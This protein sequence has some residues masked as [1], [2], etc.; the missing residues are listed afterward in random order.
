[1]KKK[2]YN[3]FIISGK[4]GT[5][6]THILGKIF[7]QSNNQKTALNFDFFKKESPLS[8]IENILNGLQ[9]NYNEVFEIYLDN[10]EDILKNLDETKEFFNRLSLNINIKVILTCNTKYLKMLTLVLKNKTIINYKIKEI[11]N[12]DFFEIYN[13][14]MNILRKNNPNLNN[15]F[16]LDLANSINTTF[17]GDFNR[18]NNFIGN[19]IK[20]KNKI[21]EDCLM[22]KDIIK[23]NIENTPLLND[24]VVLSILT[25]LNILRIPTPIFVLDYLLR[26]VGW[27]TN[28]IIDINNYLNQ[29]SDLIDSFIKQD[30]ESFVIIKNRVLGEKQFLQTLGIKLIDNNREI[31]YSEFRNWKLIDQSNVRLF[32]LWNLPSILILNKE[33]LLLEKIILDINY[34]TISF[35]EFES[36]VVLHFL[37]IIRVLTQNEN[38]QLR[39]IERLIDNNFTLLS[40][41]MLKKERVLTLLQIFSDEK[42]DK[43]FS[44]HS[45]TN[46]EKNLR[47]NI[48]E[49]KVKSN[50]HDGEVYALIKNKDKIYF[51]IKSFSNNN[52]ILYSMRIN[53]VFGETILEVEGYINDIIIQDNIIYLISSYSKLLSIKEDNGIFVV[54]VLIENQNSIFRKIFIH[55]S[56]IYIGGSMNHILK[57]STQSKT[58]EQ[59]G[60][61]KGWVYA[62]SLDLNS[63]LLVIVTNSGNIY[64]YDLDKERVSNEIQTGYSLTSSWVGEKI[65][66]SDRYGIIHMFNSNTLFEEENI[67][68][69]D[70]GIY[71]F[72]VF[73][74]RIVST[75]YSGD[76]SL[77]DC[78]TESRKIIFT[79]NQWATALE[80]SSIVNGIIFHAGMDGRVIE[81]NLETG[82]SKIIYQPSKFLSFYIS[83]MEVGIYI[84]DYLSSSISA[85]TLDGCLQL[86]I[87]LIS[88]GLIFFSRFYRKFDKIEIKNHYIK[89]KMGRFIFIGIIQKN[90]VSRFIKSKRRIKIG[91]PS[92]YFEIKYNY[93]RLIKIRKKGIINVLDE[94][95][96]EVGFFNFGSLILD[97][98][99]KDDNI[100]LLFEREG[101]KK[102]SFNSLL[103]S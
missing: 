57:Y 62:F 56:Y 36:D 16:F 102:L 3:Y 53:E 4:T 69:L 39:K 72:T 59:Y 94:N 29:I 64:T 47:F 15:D 23:S 86:S 6:K 76:L 65:Y 70:S 97:F 67:S 24:P 101:V 99:L 58:V 51:G 43:I 100:Y 89:V 9:P 45:V 2:S 88:S 40:Q 103:P 37:E 25:I 11:S 46:S 7:Q 92:E 63:K 41:T 75:H 28:E 95:E 5:G 55:E 31:I 83:K 20:S 33:L 71:E 84:F 34:W 73:G 66:L 42:N 93:K 44:Q 81:S 90:Q 82:V 80:T 32:F 18:I 52:S 74:N 78:T 1:M 98:I 85:L 38:L 12:D 96:N 50:F 48:E 30:G 26:K 35:S 21:K 22:E 68:I 14:R 10:I 87:F 17:D 54:E 13:D 61:L 49:I 79:H 60:V 77:Y 8:S 27:I 19:L 91:S